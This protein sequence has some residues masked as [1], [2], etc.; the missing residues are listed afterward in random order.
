MPC[1]DV[2]ENFFLIMRL[3]LET[4]FGCV[5]EARFASDLISKLRKIKL[6]SRPHL[7]KD[8][9]GIILIDLCM[10]YVRFFAVNRQ[11]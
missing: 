7:P 11:H 4:C 8:R 6:A 3:N 5:W 10:G 9:K 2:V 1:N